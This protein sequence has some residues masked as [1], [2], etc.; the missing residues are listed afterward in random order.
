M[1][2]FMSNSADV[3]VI[4]GGPGGLYAAE[5]LARAGMHAVVCEEH[6]RVGDPVHCTGIVAT[7]SF[8]DFDLPRGA[9]LNDLAAASFISPSG[10]KVHYTPPAPLATVIDRPAFDRALAE[11][12]VAAGVDLRVGARVSRLDVQPDGV[13]ARAGDSVIHARLAVLA[14]G[15]N[16]AF[17]RRLGLGFPAYHLHSAQ[18]E[19]PARRSSDV[20][21]H[22]GRA[23]APQGFGWA[24]P[25]T[26]S[27]GLR[28]RVGVMT[29]RDPVGCYTR[30]LDRVRDCWE[31]ED[32]GQPPR[33]KILPLGPIE[34]TVADRVMAVGD[35]AGLVKPTTGGGIYY[36]VL[37]ASLAADVAAEALRKDRL[38][39]AF[40]SAYER[41]WRRE[42]DQELDAQQAL[43]DVASQLTDEA[44]DQLFELANTDGIMPIV[45]TTARF[46]RHR[47]LIRAIFRHPP[48]RR[49]LFKHVFG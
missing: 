17:Q 45:R 11:R 2:A 27:E 48:A 47:D 34:R 1:T 10:I 4:G 26:R 44:L 38:D 8:D 6:D 20:E 12:S 5:R 40:L 37:T 30:M 14:C 23:V 9:T 13:R 21:L 15:A 35:A 3:L 43:R 42:L 16:Y 49:I 32:D 7:E 18:R 19:L 46:N 29:E 41:A 33:Q 22:F 39:A 28:V 31:I 24:V 36:A 25:V